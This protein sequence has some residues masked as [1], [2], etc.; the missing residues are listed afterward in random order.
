MN[1]L[2][3]LLTL[4]T[5][6]V[7]AC[8]RE[9]PA[10]QTTA[11]PAQTSEKTAQSGEGAKAPQSTSTTPQSEVEQAAAAQESLDDA[12]TGEDQRDVSL[13]RLAAL[14]PQQ[15][16]PGGRWKAGTNYTPIVPAQTTGVSA[17]KVEV[18]EFFWYGCGHCY[19][20]EPYIQSWMKNKPDYIEF[21]RVPAMWGPVH[22]AHAHLF[23]TL[24]ALG[25]SDL[26]PKVFET[27]H[28]RGNMLVANDENR[29]LALGEDFAKA[30]GIDAEAFRK[31]YASFSVNSNLQRAEELTRRYRVD[32]V[33]QMAV[34]G[35]YVTDVTKAGN[36][37]NLLSLIN[38]L[39]AS[40][41]R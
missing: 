23:Y 30:N 10:S 1:R 3:A 41:R 33:P 21:V 22:R 13:E 16:L 36:Q 40:E 2:L 29:S 35:K 34:N 38:D 31:A 8:G 7:C 25:R 27:I 9:Q 24:E 15:Q 5:V 26:H 14:P 39:A 6:S 32:N 17:G 20:L 19:A 18:I 37:S 4:L 11:N 12:T 28:Q